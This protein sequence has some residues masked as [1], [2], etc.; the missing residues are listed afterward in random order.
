MLCPACGRKNR[1]EE[2]SCCYCFTALNIDIDALFQAVQSGSAQH[3]HDIRPEV[4]TVEL[5]EP[6]IREESELELLSEA[7][8]QPLSPRRDFS[9]LFELCDRLQESADEETQRQ[10]LR[11]LAASALV[12]ARGLGRNIELAWGPKPLALVVEGLDDEPRGKS[13]MELLDIPMFRARYMVSG[14]KIDVVRYAE[15]RQEVQGLAYRYTQRFGKKARV[16]SKHQLQEA[17]PAVLCLGCQGKRFRIVDEPLWLRHTA[18]W[19]EE[20]ISFVPKLA[21]VGAVEKRSFRNV[22]KT[23]IRSFGRRK[24][25]TYRQKKSEERVGV[26]DL[27][28]EH[29]VLRIVEGESDFSTLPGYEKGAQRKSFQKLCS[30]L[31][32]WL[33]NIPVLSHRYMRLKSESAERVNAWPEWE[34]YSYCARFLLLETT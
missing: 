15:Q 32:V 5:V 25:E 27:H 28:G 16:V 12:A 11:K 33:S 1:P 10:L 3:S 8:L 19:Q 9:A 2:R 21:V 17:P 6:E 24:K 4:S 34:R 13:V 22:T 7:A 14:G 23:E 26:I 18:D 29:L 20:E 31:P 30:L